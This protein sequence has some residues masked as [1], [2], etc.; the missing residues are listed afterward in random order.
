MLQSNETFPT[1]EAARAALKEW[2]KNA[3]KEGYHI[4]GRVISA[5]D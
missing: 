5:K 4:I 1:R 2:K 3:E